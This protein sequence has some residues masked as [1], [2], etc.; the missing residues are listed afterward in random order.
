MTVDNFVDLKIYL[1]AIFLL[2]H[3]HASLLMDKIVI[4]SEKGL[5]SL[6]MELMH[7]VLTNGMV[8]MVT[9]A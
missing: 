2:I 9:T 5:D 1:I 7:I 8:K 4:N 3:Q 6:K